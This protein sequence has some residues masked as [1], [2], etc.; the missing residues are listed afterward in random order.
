MSEKKF[1][2]FI[3]CLGNG[4]T[5]CNKA[6]TECG[7]YK[8]IAHISEHGHIKFYVSESYIPV[9]AMKRIKEIAKADKEKFLKEWN[10][11]DYLGKWAYMMDIPTIGC[12]YNAVSLIDRDNRHLSI[13]E[14][15][16]LME[17][18]FFEMHM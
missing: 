2:L 18:A 16:E 13:E 14:R 12:G 10:K 15:V 8:Q 5:V 4:T 1:D 6:V 3:G 17:K 11:K 9:A 7:D